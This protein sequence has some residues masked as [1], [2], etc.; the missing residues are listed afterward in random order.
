MKKYRIKEEVIEIFLK[1]VSK[2]NLLGSYI[3]KPISTLNDWLN[4]N[5]W[6][7]PLTVIS[8]LEAISE[9][10]QN[11]DTIIEQSVLFSN[12]LDTRN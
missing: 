11:D 3:S 2:K 5:K 12:I 7:G 9:I 10:V 4:N 6:D 1:D 8:H